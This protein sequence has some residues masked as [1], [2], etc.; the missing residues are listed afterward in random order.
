MNNRTK[1]ITAV[2]AILLT[3]LPMMIGVVGA[4]S[5]LDLFELH[6]ESEVLDASAPVAAAVP[7]PTINAPKSVVVGVADKK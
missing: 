4:D 5:E 3:T 7:P 2:P 1:I 6:V